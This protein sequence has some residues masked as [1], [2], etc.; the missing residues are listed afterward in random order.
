MS[1]SMAT[2]TLSSKGQITIPA[3]V[4]KALHIKQQG[5]RIGFELVEWGI[6]KTISHD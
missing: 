4:R 2:A 5:E 3:K 6:D 1:V